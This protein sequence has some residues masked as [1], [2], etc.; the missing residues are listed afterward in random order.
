MDTTVVRNS[1][2]ATPSTAVIRAAATAPRIGQRPQLVWRLPAT[3]ARTAREGCSANSAT[4]SRS[5]PWAAVMARRTSPPCPSGAAPGP[6]SSPT[7]WAHSCDANLWRRLPVH[8]SSPNPQWRNVLV[9]TSRPPT[10]HYLGK[11]AGSFPR[12][13]SC[14]PY[15]G[16]SGEDESP[17]TRPWLVGLSSSTNCPINLRPAGKL[18]TL[19]DGERISTQVNSYV[20]H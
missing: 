10:S 6:G 1:F 9:Y 2:G 8:R 11:S 20:G 4:L 14:A 13:M 7:S 12:S 5:R 18:Q 16:R 3:A 15:V 17:G 19:A